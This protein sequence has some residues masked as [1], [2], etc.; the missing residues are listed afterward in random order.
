MPTA[1]RIDGMW[2]AH[3]PLLVLYGNKEADTPILRP[4]GHVA[5]QLLLVASPKSSHFS[6]TGK[7]GPS[8]LSIAYCDVSMYICD[9]DMC[10]STC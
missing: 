5:Y 4:V 8:T 10:I 9:V 7:C 3:L 6:A 1:R 2:T